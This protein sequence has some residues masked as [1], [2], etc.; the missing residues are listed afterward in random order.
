VGTASDPLVRAMQASFVPDR[1]GDFTLAPRPYWILVPGRD[2]DGGSAT[3]HG[4][5]YEYDQHV[6]LVFLGPG[7]PAAR[8]RDAASPADA[9]P[10]L[11]AAVGLALPGAEGRAVVGG[12]SLARR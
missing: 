11:A 10:T 12:P 5:S 2:P 6:P 4:T 9:A 1:S 7:F 8:R 3:T